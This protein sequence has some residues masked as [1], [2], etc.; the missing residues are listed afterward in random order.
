MN[1][2]ACTDGG[3]TLFEESLRLYTQGAL[4]QSESGLR[5]LLETHPRHFDAL[6][7]LGVI[8]ARAGRPAR[9]VE[10]LQRALAENASVAAAHRHLGNALRELG[11]L[12]EALHSYGSAIHL[13]R[14][15]KE[16]Y[17][18]RAALL[19]SLAR[20]AEALADF[21]RAMA[22]GADDALVHTYRASAL[23]DLQRPADALSS[24]DRALAKQ[25]DCTDAYVNR[26]AA[27]YLLARYEDAVASCDHAIEAQ[28]DHAAAHAQRGA[29]LYALRR[30]EAALQSLDTALLRDP[31]SAAAHNQ[32]A[33]CLLDLQ[34]PQRALDSCDR[35]IALCP[36]LID[37]HNTRGLALGDLRSFDAATA[38]FDRAIALRPEVSEPYFN[39]GVRLLQAGDF[40]RGWELYDR[41]PLLDRAVAVAAPRRPLWDGSQDLTGKT[42]FTYAEQGLGDTLQF[43]RY[44]QLLAARGARVILA[45]QGSLCSLLRS[46]GP[47]IEVVPLG[48]PPQDYDLH[49]PLLSLPRAF[50][51]RL[52]SIPA[53]VPYL[54]P[55]PDR[56]AVWR[57]L[58]R[59]EGRLIGIR[60][61]GSTGRAD[62]GRSF[63][64]R[65]FQP[66]SQI[67][68][69][70]LIS[71]QKG[72]GAEQL[73]E[74]PS[75]CQIED[76]GA[77]FEPDGPDAF[78]DVAAVMAC[79]DLVISSDTSIAHLAGALGRPTWLALKH[80]PDWRWLLDREDSPWYPSMRLFRQSSAG[81]WPGVFERM[82]RALAAAP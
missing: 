59:E 23:I 3:R 45:V 26:A 48:A 56:V 77:K 69:V 47:D 22:L 52:D 76:L 7:L 36:E 18:N 79:V 14:D 66:L 29:A 65:H 64:A 31:R 34:R 60:W 41:R 50:R 38:A 58:L 80:V 33:L 57:K 67:P 5:Q 74:L 30:L 32:R 42:L 12:E 4:A 6:H 81:D 61:Q 54:R 39:K 68:G 35:A 73:R 24:C 43:C 27:L 44:A 28:Q 49:C 72:T 53:K 13:R 82:R 70:R 78:L 9:A 19:L 1:D 17:V 16:A 20:P 51:T 55:Q 10:L 25:A 63:A 46:L 40:E 2:S 11:R 8:A 71:L 37:A 15:F 21:D 62:A 75:Q